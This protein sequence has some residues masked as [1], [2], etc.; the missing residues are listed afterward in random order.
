[1]NTSSLGILIVSR[2][3]DQTFAFTCR[4]TLESQGYRTSRAVSLGQAI[5]R[6]FI[7]R[8]V[9][10]ILDYSFKSAEQAAF[11]ECLHESY[12]DI[13]VLCL[14]YQI[15]PQVLL[16]ECKSILASQ[17]GAENVH[18]LEYACAS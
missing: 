15:P 10:V 2:D 4:Q 6:A 18:A 16:A 13:H 9:L 17:P 7:E 8:P 11:I 5:S 1:M 3:D 14:K 12:P